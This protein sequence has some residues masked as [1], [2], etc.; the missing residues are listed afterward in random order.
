MSRRHH[1]NA[2][3]VYTDVL[4]C[5]LCFTIMAMAMLILAVHPK[6]KPT[7]GVK[8]YAEYLVTL[9]W[10]DDRDVDLDLWM[11][12][13]AGKIIFYNN[14]ED[15]NVSLDRDSRGFITNRTLL[16]DG[17]PL[18]SSNREVITIRSIMPGDYLVA[19]GYFSSHES[20]QDDG[21]DIAIGF[22]VQ[23]EKVNP[24]LTPKFGG[25]F[26]FDHIKQS[27]NVVNFHVAED[28]SV[29]ILPLPAN[30]LIAEHGGGQ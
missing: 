12:D 15:V 28:G 30:S 24:I 20:S 10:P 27:V 9:T 16:P 2:F 5:I 17:T 18:F 6:A 14:R 4:S 3:T 8:P 13:P 1:H 11:Q 23:L 26:H 22:S 7:E 19:V 21:P 25:Q 29:T